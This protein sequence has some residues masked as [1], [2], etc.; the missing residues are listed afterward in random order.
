MSRYIPSLKQM[1]AR[2]NGHDQITTTEA[3]LL[4]DIAI[5][6][7]N[8]IGDGLACESTT[9]LRVCRSCTFNAAVKRVKP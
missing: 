7:Y 5:A 9:K 4:L 8:L 2:L 1:E 6:A 3:M